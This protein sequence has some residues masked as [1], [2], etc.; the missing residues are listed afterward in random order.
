MTMLI[1]TLFFVIGLAAADVS[2]QLFGTTDCTGTVITNVHSNPAAQNDSSG[3]ISPGQF[4]SHRTI[5]E[6]EGFACLLFSDDN[7]QTT[8]SANSIPGTCAFLTGN[9]IECLNVA[10]QNNPFAESIAKVTVGNNLVQVDGPGGTTLFEAVGSCGENRCDSTNKLTS[11]FDFFS[12]TGTLVVTMAGNYDTTDE[13]DYMVLLIK[14][15][16]SKGAGP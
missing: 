11:N 2:V 6:D 1:S 12:K 4:L 15:T 14:E 16:I 10:L 9:S 5:S 7:C 8:I 13:R 3:C